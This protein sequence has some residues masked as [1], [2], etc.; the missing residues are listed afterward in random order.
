MS[1]H[2]PHKN[3]LEDAKKEFVWSSLKQIG[4]HSYAQEL[5][6]DILPKLMYGT[7]EEKIKAKERLEKRES[8][9]LRALESETHV[10][11]MESFDEKHHGWLL[12]LTAKT[13]KEYNC[14]TEVEKSLASLIASSHVRIVDNSKR[15]NEHLN[16]NNSYSYTQNEIRHFEALSKQIERA[17]RQ[18]LS[19]VMALKHLKTPQIEMNIKAQTA[20]ISE[21]QQIN[22][23]ETNHEIITS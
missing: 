7:E 10:A 15:L 18:F 17:H 16:Y 3:T 2:L 12:E 6:K 13:I 8:K 4:L 9:F 22:L 21:K 1:Q 14:T 5:E 11:L 23:T 19:A 20:Y